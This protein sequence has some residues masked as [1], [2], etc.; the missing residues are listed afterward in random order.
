MLVLRDTA[1]QVKTENKALEALAAN[2]KLAVGYSVLAV[3]QRDWYSEP[4]GMEAV[5]VFPL[6]LEKHRNEEG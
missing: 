3:K 4:I 5:V 1:L 2:E 6:V